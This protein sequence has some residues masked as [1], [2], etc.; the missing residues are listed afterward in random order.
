M[1]KI[2]KTFILLF[3]ILLVQEDAFGERNWLSFGFNDFAA[4][5]IDFSQSTKE[6]ELV[7]HSILYNLNKPAPD[8]SKSIDVHAYIQ[9][10]EMTRYYISSI[11][12]SEADLNGTVN[13]MYDDTTIE[14]LKL[15][16]NSDEYL[17]WSEICSLD[18][19]QF[20]KLREIQVQ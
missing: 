4:Y 20:A 17:F 13:K 3:I 14:P 12:Y 9:C 8:G 1:Y 5:Y 6:Q 15:P 16:I 11:W 7:Y 18:N 10:D 2:I 19:S